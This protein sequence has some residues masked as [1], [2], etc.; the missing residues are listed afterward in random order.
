MKKIIKK[1]NQIA[2]INGFSMKVFL[3]S[4]RGIPLFL[5]N[6]LSYQ[7]AFRKNGGMGLQ[8]SNLFPV[9]AD[10]YDSAGVANGHYFFQD[11][12]AAKKIYSIKPYKHVDIG[13]SV[14]GFVSHLL[15]FMECVEVVDVRSL[16]S[17]VDQLIFIQDDG[18]YLKSYAD[19][20]LESVSS[21][22][23]AEHFGLGRY[24]DPID[25]L[26]HAK[27]MNSLARVLKPGGRLYFSVPT[28]IERLEFNA[29]RVLSPATV[30]NCFSS[31]D[32]ISFS[33]VKDD[34]YIYENASLEDAALQSY[35]CGLYEFSK[36][37]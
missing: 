6:L 12:W 27:F 26:A 34:G 2:Q 35:G 23:A 18:T 33:L 25:P 30:L 37:L 3:L 8:F 28:G 22:H 20:S 9:M 4:I 19:N 5:S 29:H 24:G 17:K 16:E 10:R 7:I 11:L 14:M 36:K 21:L 31:L 13:S 32:L 15:V 1:L